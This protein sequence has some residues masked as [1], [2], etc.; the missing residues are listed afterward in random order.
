MGVDK[1]KIKVGAYEVFVKQAEIKDAILHTK[2]GDILPSNKVLSS[3]GIE[4]VL[5]EKREFILRDAL[6]TIRDKY[7]YILI[8][9]PPSLEMLT[10][11]S[12]NAADG[13]LIPVQCEYFALEGLSDLMNSVRLIKRGFNPNIEIDGVLLTMFDGRTNL[14]FQ[15]ADEVKKFFKDKVYHVM[16][17]RNVRLSE[18]PSYGKPVLE[19]DYTSRGAQ[20]YLE[21]AKEVIRRN[22]QKGV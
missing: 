17:P 4:I 22:E 12:L 11:N 14:S 2:Y 8:D 15:V 7:D 5:M 16:I 19:Y 3:A 6:N 13:V 9:C 1:N 18:A 21:L 10:L 20:A